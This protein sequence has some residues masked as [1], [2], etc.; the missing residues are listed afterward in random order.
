MCK[1][2]LGTWKVGSQNEC[3]PGNY[4][5]AEV[6]GT[7]TGTVNDEVKTAIESVVSKII[8]EKLG[9]DASK[10]DVSVDTTTNSDGTTTFKVAVKVGN[11][12]VTSDQFSDIS[13][14]PTSELE[15]QLAAQG[16]NAQSGT[17]NIS[18]NNFAGK[19]FASLLFV[20]VSLLF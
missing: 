13:K 20:A 10:V 9:I 12:E 1:R 4:Y 5:E 7:V 16:I 2:E 15:S 19:L 8:A 18:N 14:I 11:T 3:I 17:V 6:K